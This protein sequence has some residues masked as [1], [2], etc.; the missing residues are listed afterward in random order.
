MGGEGLVQHES[1]KH[2]RRQVSGGL[3]GPGGVMA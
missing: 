2:F 3:E 1:W